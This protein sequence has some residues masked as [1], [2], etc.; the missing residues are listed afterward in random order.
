MTKNEEMVLREHIAMD[1]QNLVTDGIEFEG[2]TTEGLAFSFEDRIIVIKTIVKK[3]DFDVVDAMQ[4]YEEK[5]KAR[6]E[7]EEKKRS[8]LEKVEKEKKKKSA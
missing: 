4:E 1:L 7:R 3:E 8:K 2:R 6:L 5:E